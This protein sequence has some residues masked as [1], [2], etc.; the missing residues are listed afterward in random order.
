MFPEFPPA[1]P[2]VIWPVLLLLAWAVGEGL[3]ARWRVPR[4]SSYVAV[5][6]L[7]GYL[8]QPALHHGMPG[9]FFLANT[10]LA[11]VLFELGYRIHLRW[12]W[13]N[14]WVLALGLVESALT[15]GAVYWASGGFGLSTEVRLITAAL[16]MS[17]SPAGIVRVAN[18]LRGAGQVTERVMH[19]CAINCLLAVLVLKLVVG[20]W[21][22]STSGDLA[23]AALGSV[24]ALLMSVALGAALG[25]V[26]PWLWRARPVP[27]ASVTA[28]FALAVLLLVTV[29]QALML[30]PLLAAL[31][32]GVVARERRVHLTPAQ[33][34]FG[35]AGDVL[36][37]FLFVYVASLIDWAAVPA[38]LGLAVVLLAVRVAS[39]VLCNVAVARVSGITWRKG[40]LTGLALTPMSAFA[41]L[42]LEQSQ[43]L[44]FGPATAVLSALAAMM[45]LQELLGPWVTQRSLMA[46]R[47]TRP[48]TSPGRAPQA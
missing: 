17:A 11:L 1:F 14:P 4:V 30:S 37:L 5:G 13:H 34:G 33:R 26:V 36:G 31:S 3:H 35:S 25:V 21:H 9:L 40:A 44:G 29:S 45:L 8:A 32:F 6:L 16:A 24:Y 12:F 48:M 47:E 7:A 46:A 42:L 23:A 2:A 22:L 20:H 10:A 38:T 15:F 18:E 41:I 39:K 28:V 19:L 43:R 27:E